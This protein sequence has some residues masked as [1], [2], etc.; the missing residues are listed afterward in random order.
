LVDVRS[1]GEYAEGHVEGAINIPIQELTEN[2]ALMPD[3]DANIVVYCGSGHRS[4]LVM[5]A[6]N[7]LG[8][9][10]VVSLMG[11]VRALADQDIPLVQAEPAVEAGDMP[12]V[13][14]NV[15]PLVADYMTNM[16]DGYYIVRAGD[17]NSELAEG[18][19]V[20]IDVRT[21]GEYD[22]GY[23]EGA[24]HIPFSELMTSMDMWPEDMAANIVVYDN[25]THR[26]S[27]AMMLMQLLGY[28]NVRT[29]GG[30]TG[31]WQGADL[32]L[33]TE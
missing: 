13:N 7:L 26:S 18:D 33:V 17:L 4:A 30:G 12:A 10:D 15:L 8:Y 31:A 24:V 21:Q 1:P 19:I 11:G 27:M 28:E 6:M 16:P 14:E 5:E 25:P 32:P 20:L 9:T 3:L 2:L 23:I 22:A 29:L